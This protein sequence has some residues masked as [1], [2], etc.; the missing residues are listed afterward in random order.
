VE[1]ETALKKF[2]NNK[3]P[4]TAELPRFGSDRL[5]QWLKRVSSSI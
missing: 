5:K 2:E 4:G 1:I 3:A